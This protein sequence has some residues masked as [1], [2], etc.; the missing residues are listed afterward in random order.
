M[1]LNGKTQ[2]GLAFDKYT[3]DEVFNMHYNKYLANEP[4]LSVKIGAVRQVQ[5]LFS[6]EDNH[7]YVFRQTALDMASRIKLDK[8][9]F[10]DLS[11]ITDKLPAK[12]C[13][14]LMG[15]EKFYRWFRWDDDSD[16]M[17]L[18]VKMTPTGDE[19]KEDVTALMEM[20][21]MP[22]AQLRK[23]INDKKAAGTITQYEYDFI[24]SAVN[25][26]DFR[27][28]ASNGIFY[29]LWGIKQGKLHFPPD[30]RNEDFDNEMLEFVRLLIFTE[31]SEIETIELNPRQSFGT[32][33]QGKYLN[34]SNKS[35]RIVDSSWNK[36]LIKGQGFHVNSHL[37]L[38]SYGPGMKYKRL[39][40]IDGFEKE[41]YTRNALKET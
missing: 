29:Y 4:D 6:N 31:L 28:Q 23:L 27:K 26:K 16:I 17:V 3:Q 11:F 19:H 10:E 13:T 40:Y 36:I 5:D 38:Q 35:V 30:E 20:L 8:G 33:K 15:K 18:C 12:K 7:N 1:I 14:F 37:R 39:Q 21:K 2:L 34:E 32:R 24:M 25:N 41:G 22:E 9:K